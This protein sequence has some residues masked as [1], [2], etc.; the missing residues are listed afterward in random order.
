MREAN[1][2]EMH[3]EN[4]LGSYRT[5]HMTTTIKNDDRKVVHA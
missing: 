2:A 1:V 5:S 4:N 3:L